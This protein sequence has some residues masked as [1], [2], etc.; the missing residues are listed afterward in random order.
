MTIQYHCKAIKLNELFVDIFLHTSWLE[1]IIIET[2]SPHLV[3]KNK[4]LKFHYNLI[5]DRVYQCK[6]FLVHI[7]DEI[8]PGKLTNLLSPSDKV[9]SKTYRNVFLTLLIDPMFQTPNKQ[10]EINDSSSQKKYPNNIWLIGSLIK[11][12]I[13]L[14]RLYQYTCSI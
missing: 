2:F 9:R 12:L 10:K 11:W 6:K 14:L 4:P 1:I 5:Q 13:K 7:N 8:T 3:G